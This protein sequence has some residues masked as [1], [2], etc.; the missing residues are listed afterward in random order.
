MARLPAI[1]EQSHANFVRLGVALVMLGVGTLVSMLLTGPACDRYGSRRVLT[2]SF[3]VS[4][5][6]LLAI[7]LSHSPRALAVALLAAGIG[8][9]A[10]DAGMNMQAYAVENELRKHLMSRFHGWWS[11]G[12]MTGAAAGLLAARFSISLFTQLAAVSLLAAA[13]CVSCRHSLV[14]A[15]AA[16]PDA[17][18]PRP[19]WPIRRL[20][21]IGILLFCGATVEGAAADWLAVYL[22]E[23]RRLSHTGAAVGYTVFV[24]AMAAG[25]LAAERP[26]RHVGAVGVVRTGAFLAAVCILLIVLTPADSWVFV[27]A[28]GWGVG[29][30]WAFPAALSAT[31]NTA[32]PSAVAAMTAV[33]YSASIV[34]PLVIGRL[35]HA[36]GLGTAIVTLTPLVL[37]VALLAPALAGAA[38]DPSK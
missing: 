28:F 35:A 8:S 5:L 34:G 31:G 3:A 20:V 17:V 33:G 16:Q 27:G 21:P 32:S 15:K 38:P 23:E 24:S 9:G 10:W 25:R 11:V 37:V 14:E 7:A 1:L 30:C 26:H 18:R 4:L 6:S 13:L 36:A 12:S 22:N 29:I 2:L 19:R